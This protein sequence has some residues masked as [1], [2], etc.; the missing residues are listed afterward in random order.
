MP[1]VD[2]GFPDTPSASGDLLLVRYGPTLTVRVGFDPTFNPGSKVTPQ[3]PDRAVNAL[4]D[5]G[6]MTS[7]ID[8]NLVK[9]LNLPFVDRR[10]FGGI[11]GAS[12]RPI[13]LAQIEVPDL[14]FT[15]YGR[16]A[17][18]NLA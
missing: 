15:I 6:A 2:C 4:V 11:D 1:I 17:A 12:E 3:L 13:H 14:A 9:A 8:T 7:C 5:T 10:D 16:F 18:V